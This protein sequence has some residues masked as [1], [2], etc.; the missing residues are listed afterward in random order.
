MTE[1]AAEPIADEYICHYCGRPAEQGRPW[2]FVTDD[3]QTVPAHGDC[4]EARGQEP[5]APD[6]GPVGG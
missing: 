4:A 3:G 1:S 2:V 5:S 6:T